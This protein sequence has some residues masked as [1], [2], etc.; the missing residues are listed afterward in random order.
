MLPLSRILILIASIFAYDKKNPAI[1]NKIC[2]LS[3]ATICNR[4]NFWMGFD[5]GGA[6]E[7]LQLYIN[8]NVENGR[9]Q[10][11]TRNRNS[12]SETI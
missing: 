7:R 8:F 11:T 12:G 4:N 1:Y 5:F 9:K 6:I 2:A 10:V 3:H